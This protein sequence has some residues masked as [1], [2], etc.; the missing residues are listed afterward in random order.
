M[1]FSTSTQAPITFKHDVYRSLCRV[2]VGAVLL[3]A[4]SASLAASKI[5]VGTVVWIGYGPFYVA[6][7]LNLYKKYDLDVKLKVFSDPALI[8]AALASGSVQGAMLTYDQVIGQVALGMQ[9][10]LSLIHI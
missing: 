8:P 10:R 9:Q 2:A 3:I 6:E 5:N 7:S 4:A 1:P